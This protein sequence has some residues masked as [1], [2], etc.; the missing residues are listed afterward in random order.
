MKILL[1]ENMP[2]S[3]VFSLGEDHAVMSVRD[4]GWL[5]KKNGELLGLAV[6][7]GFEIFITLDKNLR[8]QQNLSKFPIK[9]III[10][11][12]NNLIQTMVTFIPVIKTLLDDHLIINQINIIGPDGILIQLN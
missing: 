12:K 2:Q 5:G 3:S 11:S 6:M 8:F 7:N 4:M 1:D 9:F 10:H